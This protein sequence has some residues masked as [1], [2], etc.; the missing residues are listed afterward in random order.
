MKALTIAPCLCGG[1]EENCPE[2]GGSGWNDNPPPGMHEA[3]FLAGAASKLLNHLDASCV[4]Y[5]TRKQLM[6][7][8]E[9]D[10]ASECWCG[11]E[12]V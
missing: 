9:C 4:P 1:M 5:T 2:C 10:G 6:P 8:P 12:P 7:C 3:R 11:G